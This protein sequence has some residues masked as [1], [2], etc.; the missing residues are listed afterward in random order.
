MLDFFSAPQSTWQWSKECRWCSVWY[1]PE[2]KYWST[3]SWEI[4]GGKRAKLFWNRNHLNNIIIITIIWL[5]EGATLLWNSHERFTNQRND[6]KSTK[7]SS[8]IEFRRRHFRNTKTQSRNIQIGHSAEY[9]SDIKSLPTSVHRTGLFELFGFKFIHLLLLWIFS[10]ID[11]K[12]SSHFSSFFF[13]NKSYK[14][15]R[16]HL[17]EVQ[18]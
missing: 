17:L 1:V 3:S 2:W 4:L 11:L 18:E 16:R 15:Y 5:I 6:G 9:R 13:Q 7:S 10:L 14:R 8:F 12:L